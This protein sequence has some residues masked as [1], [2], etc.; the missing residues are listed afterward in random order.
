MPSS[1]PTAAS[2]NGTRCSPPAF[3]RDAGT[4]HSRASRSTS[5]HLAP[6]A[7]PDRTAVIYGD[8]ITDTGADNYLYALDAR[9]GRL[10]WETEILDYL[11]LDALKPHDLHN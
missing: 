9:T 7:S 1:T 5:P 6:R 11:Y 3:I 8:D 4:R 2:D 10:A